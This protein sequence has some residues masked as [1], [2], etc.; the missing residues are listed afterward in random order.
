VQGNEKEQWNYGQSLPNHP[1]IVDTHNHVSR[2]G[3]QRNLKAVCYS[4]ISHES[5]WNVRD[6]VALI[7]D[8]PKS[9]ASQSISLT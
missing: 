1:I 3:K 4:M 9:H 7:V 6:L 5:W 2:S 8:P